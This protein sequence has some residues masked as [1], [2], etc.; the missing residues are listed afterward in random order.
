MWNEPFGLTSI[1]AMA[2]GVPVLAFDKG[3]MREIILEG[4][5]GFVVSNAKQMAKK[6][7]E[8]NS[9]NRSLISQYAKSHFSAETM[10]ANYLKVYEKLIRAR[11]LQTNHWHYAVEKTNA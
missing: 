7:K 10:A 8:I 2:M 3:P 9:L 6:L 4:K 11:Q 1:E 5:T